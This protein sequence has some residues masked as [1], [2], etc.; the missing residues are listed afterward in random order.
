MFLPSSPML[1]VLLHTRS[2]GFFSFFQNARPAGMRFEK[3]EKK[4]QLACVQ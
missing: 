3:S 1:M 4:K 2:N